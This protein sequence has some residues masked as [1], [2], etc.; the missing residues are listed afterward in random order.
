MANQVL[1]IEDKKNE[2]FLRQKTAE[3]DFNK[4]SRRE[5]N[6]LISKMRKLMRSAGGIGLSANQIGLNLKMFVAE[7]PNLK[8]GHKFYAIFNPRIEKAGGEKEVLEEGCLSVPSSYG[9]VERSKKVTLVGYDKNAKP[10]KIKA[11]GL[12]ARVFQHEVD[13]LNGLL[14]LDKTK[15]VRKITNAAN[16]VEK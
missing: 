7:V 3:F 4:F 2:K 15:V 16:G 1:T 10:I 5:I 9:M 12:L 8:G 11:W 14:F 6:E 13:H